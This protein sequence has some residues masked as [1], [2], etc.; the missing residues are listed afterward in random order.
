M[1][2]GVTAEAGM[3]HSRSFVDILSRLSRS[4]N[5][6]DCEK[7]A[8]ECISL[9]QGRLHLSLTPLGWKTK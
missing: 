9:G 6:Q 3:W 4:P 7:A 1:V 8:V 2:A 5:N